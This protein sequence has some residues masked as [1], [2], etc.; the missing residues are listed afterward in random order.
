MILRSQLAFL[1]WILLSSSSGSA[2]SAPNTKSKQVET[3]EIFCWKLILKGRLV[4]TFEF[5]QC[6][7]V[8]G[9]TCKIT[10][11]DGARLPSRVF[12]QALDSH[13]EPLGNRLLLPYPR[14]KP[15][16]F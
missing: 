5:A 2:Q 16:E 4:D 14:L 15:G 10:L 3:C 1:L 9:M 13:D 8:S 11:K 12:V 7:A 6:D